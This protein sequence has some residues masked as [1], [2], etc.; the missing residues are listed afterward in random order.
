MPFLLDNCYYLAL[1]RAL[2]ALCVWTAEISGSS[3]GSL[4]KGNR[5]KLPHSA[6]RVLTLRRACWCCKSFPPLRTCAVKQ[7]P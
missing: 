1:D 7:I 4:M 2:V 5:S 3:E 6:S